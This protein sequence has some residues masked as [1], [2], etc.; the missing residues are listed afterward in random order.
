[1]RKSGAP[2]QFEATPFDATK[3][4]VTADVRS[5]IAP[6]VRD[7][8]VLLARWQ[9]RIERELAARL[10]RADRA[11]GASARG[12]ALQRARRRQARAAALVYATAARSRFL[13]RS[14]T[15]PPAPSSSSTPTRSC[16]TIC[17]RWTTT[18]C[19]AVGRPVTRRSMK[20]RRSWSATRCRCSPSRS[21]QAVRVCRTTP[22][23][24]LQLVDLL[25]VGERHARH[26]WRTSARSRGHGPAA[27][28]RRSRRHARSQDRRAD[29]CVRDDGRGLRTGPGRTVA[30]RARSLC[31]RHRTRLSD[32]GRPARRRRRCGAARQGDRRRS[33]ARQTH[34]SSRR[35]RRGRT[36]VACTSC[37]RTRLQRLQT[38]GRRPAPLASLSR[39]AR[40]SP[41]LA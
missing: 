2:D 18:T 4:I 19:G 3:M 15:A 5:A 20:R 7:F 28:D 17:R 10:P 8:A 32:S 25:A 37:M 23:V 21:S 34:L 31:A 27:R 36:H 35:R 38:V 14:S 26:G 1:M 29:S 12:H 13:S 11:A 6:R 9:A 22:R 24:R 33:R 41:P 30:R 39:L 16:M 40:P